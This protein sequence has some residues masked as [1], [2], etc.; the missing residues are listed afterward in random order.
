MIR[1]LLSV[2]RFLAKDSGHAMVEYLFM[3]SLILVAA[4]L[5]I[6]AVGNATLDLFERSRDALP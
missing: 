2:R 3:I 1:I 5:G 4:I 6:T